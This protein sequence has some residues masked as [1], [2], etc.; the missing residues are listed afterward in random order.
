MYVNVSE[1][2]GWLKKHW[3]WVSEK[4]IW[5]SKERDMLICLFLLGCC[6]TWE[7]MRCKQKGVPQGQHFKGSNE[8]HMLDG[9][10]M[11]HAESK[12]RVMCTGHGV[13]RCING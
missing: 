4:H 12:A 7:V 8:M 13:T 2:N 3:C 5:F 1:A 11:R 6:Q 10:V 9:A